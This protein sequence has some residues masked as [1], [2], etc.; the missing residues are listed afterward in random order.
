LLAASSLVDIAIASTL[1]VA[2]IAMAPIPAVVVAGALS[3]AV[4]F[5]LVLD[6]IKLPVFAHLGIAENT[7]SSHTAGRAKSKPNS[8]TQITAE[9]P[10]LSDAKPAATPQIQSEIKPEDSAKS[11]NPPDSKIEVAP[12][13]K[14]AVQPENKPDAAAAMASDA[15]PQ[16]VKRVHELYETL[17]REDVQA[18]QK[19]DKAH[20]KV[21]AENK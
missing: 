12:V 7:A 4:L 16:M 13:I 19:W 11:Q 20:E 3:A 1:A 17:G 8:K 14:A 21:P 9:Q 6:L 5:A 18:V 2:G 10:K 15:T